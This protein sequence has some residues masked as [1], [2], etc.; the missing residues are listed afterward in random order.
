[1]M[2]ERPDLF[3]NMAEMEHKLTELRGAPVTMNKDQGKK[4][5]EEVK[6]TGDKTRAFVFLKPH[7]DYPHIKDISQME[8]REPKPL[9]ECNG[10]C[11]TMDL[12]PKNETAEEINFD[13]DGQTKLEL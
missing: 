4:A 5:K 11:G 6:S 12:S 3:D 13:E 1:M 2:R 8:G 10:F 9:V 7:P